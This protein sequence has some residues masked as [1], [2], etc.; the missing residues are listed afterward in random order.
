[1]TFGEKLYRLRK[2]KGMSQEALAEKINTTRQAI[3]K[4][5][6]DQGYPETEKLLMIG[7]IFEVSMDYLLKDG[8]DQSSEKVDDG[9]YV[10]KEM[11]E[12][13][14]NQTP[15]VANY[16]AFGVSAIIMA[17]LPY[18]MFP[19]DPSTYTFMMMIF[20]IAAVL[21]FIGAGAKEDSQYNVLKKESLLFDQNYLRHLTARYEMIKKKNAWILSF[22]VV[23]IVIGASAFLLER[24]GFAD[25]VLLPYYPW[26]IA[27]T[28]I[29]A[30][31]VVRIMSI[32][33]AY[34]L[35]VKNEERTNKFTFK[36]KKKF[37]EKIDDL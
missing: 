3:S 13:Y 37:K 34:E 35:L 11:A 8:S 20:V 28:A 24:R 7:N 17:F 9:Y 5:E 27:V 36:L 21:S 10:S 25:G 4:W 30:F 2:G 12:G 1:M 26:F 33:E 15:T 23:L 14:L 6:N 18:Y 32:N 31:I 29:G 22:G 19:G 16:M